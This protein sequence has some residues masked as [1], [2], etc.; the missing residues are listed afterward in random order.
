MREEERAR[1]SRNELWGAAGAQAAFG[2][3]PARAGREVLQTTGHPGPPAVRGRR[4]S[5]GVPYG[6][7][8]PLLWLW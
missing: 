8:V 6:V 1:E 2:S 7:R 3:V 5:T 4:L